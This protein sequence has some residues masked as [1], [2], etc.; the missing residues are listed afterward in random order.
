MV[1][2]LSTLKKLV[3]VGWK[4]SE[5]RVVMNAAHDSTRKQKTG[6]FGLKQ[7]FA[8]TNIL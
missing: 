4:R 8:K 6:W 3:L 7:P 1:Q 5:I 2:Y